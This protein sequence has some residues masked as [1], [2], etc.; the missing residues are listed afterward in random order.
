MDSRL[1]LI[2][3][4]IISYFLFAKKYLRGYIT[5]VCVLLFLEAA[6][7][8]V[9]V[10]IDTYAYY[11]EFFNA[12]SYT[13]SSILSEFKD[14]YIDQGFTRDPGYFI[15]EKLFL[16]FSDNWQLYLS[17][18]TALFFFG[19]W[20]LLIL[21]VEKPIHALFAFILYVALFHIIVICVLRQ[22]I[23]MGIFFLSTPLLIKRKWVPFVIIVLLSSTIHQSFLLTLF[24]IPL[25]F[26][27]SSS[28]KRLLLVFF[29]AVPAI[30]L[31][32]R[33]IIAFM[34]TQIESEYYMGYAESEGRGG[35]VLYFLLCAAVA[36]YVYFCSQEFCSRKRSLYMSG[37]ILLTATSPLIIVDGAMIRISQ[38]F[39]FFMMF[40]IPIAFD[41]NK[42]ISQALYI[43]TMAALIFLTFRSEFSYNFFWQSVP[44]YGLFR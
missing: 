3:I 28:R 11:L 16:L 21:N 41:H 29:F 18:I 22:A 30:V 40:A 42:K 1:I 35:A 32:A 7:R 15:V 4:I 6:L 19:L 14:A 2:P 39:A 10:G 20:R 17:S 44:G 31:N 5:F 33:L 38:Y 25:L 43:G 24:M 34:A 37:I 9:S 27:G 13:W 23:C 26:I 12:K 8:H 36:I